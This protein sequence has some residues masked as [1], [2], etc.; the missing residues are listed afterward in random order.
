MITFPNAKINIGLNVVSKRPDGYHNLETVYYP[1]PI[2]DSLEIHVNEMQSAPITLY[3]YG[4]EI[5]GDLAD[6]LIVKAY[7]LI[8][9]DFDIPCLDAYLYKNIPSGAG[10]GGGSSNAAFML[11]LLNKKFK[12]NISTKKLEEYALRLGADCP[13]FIQN[14]PVFAQGIGNLFSSIPLDLKDYK[15]VLIKPE[16]S[17]STP[18]A[19][20]QIRAQKPENP[21]LDCI[22]LPLPQWKDYITNDFEK[23]IFETYPELKEIKNHLY[24]SG[25]LYASMSGSGPSIY[26]IYQTGKA[27]PD[28]SLFQ[29]Y[30]V[31]NL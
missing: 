2:E 6:N 25:A 1:I 13:F 23:P 7:N 5:E 10:L 19:F 27:L 14:K 3:A 31:C 28:L 16:I 4:K 8:K 18:K 29:E 20:R 17:I 22:N 12:L 11:K 9:K 21:L 15:I 24:Q 26:G 30:Y